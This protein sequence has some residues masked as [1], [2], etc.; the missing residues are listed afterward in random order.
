MAMVMPPVLM[1]QAPNMRR[2]MHGPTVP[3]SS[4]QQ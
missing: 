3:P 1:P 4:S 2:A